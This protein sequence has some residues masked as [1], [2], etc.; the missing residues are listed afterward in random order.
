M[1]VQEPVEVPCPVRAVTRGPR[2]HYFGYYDKHCWDA[3]GRVILALAVDF[4]DRSQGPQDAAVIG[5]IDTLDG[6]RFLPL[7]ETYAWNW[8]QGTMLHWLDSGEG[9]RFI[10]NDRRD[11]R[12]LSVIRDTEGR[13]ERTLPLPV[14]NV[15]ADGRLAVTLN[16]A[17]LH[18]T[19][20]GYGYCCV[21]DPGQGVPAPEDDGVWVMDLESGE[22][23][24][25][26]TVAQMAANRP[27]GRM[28]GAEHWFNHLLWNEDATRFIFLHRWARPG[29]GW[30]TRLYT[31]DPEGRDVHLLA[32]EGMVSHFDWR[33][34][35][36]VLAWSRQGAREA[37]H[38]FEDGGDGVEVLGAE[39]FSTD[40]HCSYDPSETWILT[41]T[42]PDATHHRT[43]ILYDTRTGRRHDIGRFYAPPE[44][45]GELRCDLHPR[46][47]RDGRQVCIDSMHE[48]GRQMWVLDVSSVVDG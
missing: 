31:S 42:Y 17:R 46:W 43:L 32:D 3:A 37:Y 29:Q 25:V 40:G 19:R 26:I 12:F 35:D 11:G 41:D 48:A 36:R 24:L 6:D 16:F 33:G 5:L 9:R 4:Y 21:R 10:H 2:F 45:D 7:A 20:P 15:S 14:Y 30:S 8:Q 27:D 23:R 44:Y 47:S 38:L 22:H 39:A 13:E 28:E 18:R 34:R 1:G